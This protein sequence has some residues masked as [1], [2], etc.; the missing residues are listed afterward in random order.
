MTRCTTCKG[1]GSIRL[2]RRIVQPGAIGIRPR[3]ARKTCCPACLGTP[4]R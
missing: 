2:P 3:H 4:Y 1:K